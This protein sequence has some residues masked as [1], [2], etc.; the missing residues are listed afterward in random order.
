MA[1][2][3]T[4]ES[5][6]FLWLRHKPSGFRN[7]VPDMSL[8]DM[9]ILDPAS[10]LR[11]VIVRPREGS[12]TGDLHKA[13]LGSLAACP[14]TTQLRSIPTMFMFLAFYVVMTAQLAWAAQTCMLVA[15]SPSANPPA[16]A[17]SSRR[18]SASSSANPA[19]TSA[20][21]SP[22]CPTSISPG[23]IVATAWYAGWHSSNFT[24]QNV[25][26][27]KYTSLIYAFA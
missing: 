19:A 5:P 26:W 27:S 13:C 17:S 4:S 7:L 8:V 24:L 20:G 3:I 16:Q 21:A 6:I 25:S 9:T 15:A 11:Q 23:P 12:R 22:S 1:W 2:D 18:P 14:L 10:A